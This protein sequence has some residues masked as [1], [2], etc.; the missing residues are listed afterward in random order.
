MGA[1]VLYL[2]SNEIWG[3]E[4]GEC[5]LDAVSAVA[6]PRGV[7]AGGATGLFLKA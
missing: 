2:G 6:I 7:R 3:V 4:E 1:S 5:C